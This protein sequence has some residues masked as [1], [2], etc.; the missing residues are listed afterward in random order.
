VERRLQLSPHPDWFVRSAIAI[1]GILGAAGIAA[2]A[3]ASHAGD[4]AILGPLALVALTQAPAIVALALLGGGRL[5]AIATALIAIGALLF[6]ADLALRHFLGGSPI[7][8]TAPIG[9][10]AMVAGWALLVPAAFN[11]GR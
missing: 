9:G 4:A 10:T 11:V 3:A 6:C 2:A 1:A 5:T 8:F 7:A